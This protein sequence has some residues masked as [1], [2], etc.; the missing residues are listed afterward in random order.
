[1]CVTVITHYAKYPHM[2]I[3]LVQVMYGYCCIEVCI[4]SV[5]DCQAFSEVHVC[6]CALHYLVFARQ[7]I[8]IYSSQTFKDQ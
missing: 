1:M 6:S 5:C 7:F 2:F 8:C 3:Y 4:C